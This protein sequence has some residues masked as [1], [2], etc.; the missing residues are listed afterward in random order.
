MTS[1]D[2]GPTWSDI[3]RWYDDLVRAGSGP[4][5]TALDCLLRLVPPLGGA[6]VLDLA[7][8]QGLASRALADSGA[9]RVVGVDASAAMIELA[10]GHDTARSNGVSYVVDDGQELAGPRRPGGHGATGRLTPVVPGPAGSRGR[11]PCGPGGRWGQ[12]LPPRSAV[13]AAPAGLRQ[14]GETFGRRSSATS[15]IVGSTTPSTSAAMAATWSLVSNT[16]RWRAWYT[17]WGTE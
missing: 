14:P 9:R 17:R 6:E 12:C 2:S 10:R 8:G 3:A 11:G 4:H 13:D 1:A 5:E 16:S 15:T 7:C